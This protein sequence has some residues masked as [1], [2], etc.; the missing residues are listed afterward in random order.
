MRRKRASR[1][2]TPN[3][4]HALPRSAEKGVPFIDFHAVLKDI[5]PFRPKYNRKIVKRRR[6]NA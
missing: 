1:D 6:K 4:G 2:I 5:I 3:E